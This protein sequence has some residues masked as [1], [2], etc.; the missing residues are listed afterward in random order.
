[1]QGDLMP[2]RAYHHGMRGLAEIRVVDLCDEIAGPYATKL[3]ADAGADV[4]KLESA[5][6]DPLRR[7][8]AT[9]GLENSE[10]DS[11]LFRFLNFSKR[12]VIGSPDDSEIREL[13]AGADLVV[14]SLAPGSLDAAA[15]AREESGLVVMSISH[16]TVEKKCTVMDQENALVE[17]RPTLTLALIPVNS[18]TVNSVSLAVF[19]FCF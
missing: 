6:G 7:G 11:A 17:E 15:L 10:E 13:I 2:G 3:L 9:A 18:M 4:V 5:T 16:L 8:S 14:E 1:M 12:S 19:L